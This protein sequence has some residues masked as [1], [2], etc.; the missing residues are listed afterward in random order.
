MLI[1]FY[2][3]CY[4]NEWVISGNRKKKHQGSN[5]TQ[6]IDSIS[7]GKQQ[8]DSPRQSRGS[9][10]GIHKTTTHYSYHGD[11][12]LLPFLGTS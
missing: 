5:T 1:T 8:K 6:G 10:G 12:I 2:I 4:Q 3:L 7:T 9:R 11:I